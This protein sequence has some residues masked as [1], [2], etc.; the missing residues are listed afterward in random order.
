MAP[1]TSA[2]DYP[3]VCNYYFHAYIVLISRQLA[4]NQLK[5][6]TQPHQVGTSARMLQETIII[7][8][9]ITDAVAAL[10]E[11]DS[12]NNDH[13][14]LIRLMFRTF[15]TWFENTKAAPAKA[16][17]SLNLPQDHLIAT[18]HRIQHPFSRPHRRLQNHPG[19]GFIVCRSIKSN[20]F[21]RSELLQGEKIPLSSVA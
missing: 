14:S 12:R 13:V 19:I 7:A 2:A 21:G 10:V 6:M 15:G 9:S 11:H 3:P 5:I 20:A 1:V 4:V 16:G 8:L 18:Y 17:N